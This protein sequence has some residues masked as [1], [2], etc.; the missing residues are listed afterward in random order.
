[1][2]LRLQ[3][4]LAAENIS[5]SQFADEIGVARAS[6]SHIIAGRNRPGYDFLSSMIAHY[7]TLNVEWLLTGKGKMYKGRHDDEDLLFKGDPAMSPVI[8]AGMTVTPVSESATLFDAPSPAEAVSDAHTSAPDAET[9]ATIEIN[10]SNN[11]AQSSKNQR[12]AIKVIVFYDDGTF[13]EL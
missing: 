3:Q 1:M 13:Q 7:P 5:Q 4:F 8:P 11:A 10:T 6:V 12:K 9:A 2:N